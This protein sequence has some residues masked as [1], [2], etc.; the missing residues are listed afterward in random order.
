MIKRLLPWIAA[1]IGGILHFLGYVGFDQFY[2]EWIFLVPLLWAVR[3]QRPGRAFLIGWVAGIVG[4]A[5]GFYWIIQMFQQFAGVPWPLAALGL[6]F[7]S[8]A[9]GIVVATWAWATRLITRDTG[10]SVVWVAP[11]VWTAVEKFWPEIF[12]NYLGA[13]QYRLSSLTQIADL[14]GILGVS[15]LVVYINATI[16][17][18]ATCFVEKRRLAWR[19]LT[20]LAAAIVLVVCYGELRI[21]AMD[22]QVATAE[23]LTIGL[24]QVNRGAADTHIDPDTVLREHHE[25]SRT[26]VAGHPLDL[27]VWPEGVCRVN[28]SSR[29]SRLPTALLGDLGTP[30]LLGACLQLWDGDK[31][32]TSN[33]ALLTDASGRIIGSYDKTIL[34]PFGEYIP[35]GDIFPRLYSWSPFVSR[36][37]PGASEEPLLL[38]RHLLSVNICYED[39]FPGHIRKLMRGGRERRVPE[40]MF[41]LTND[42][43]YG[44]STEPMEHLA[45]ASFR[46][47]ENRRSLVRVTNTG[48]SAFVDPVGRIVSRTGVWTK[49]V[50]VDRIPLLKGRTAYAVMG[51]WIG[52]LCAAF[53]ISGIVQAFRISRRG[54]ELGRPRDE[55]D[56]KRQKGNRSEG[57]PPAR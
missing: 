37:W 27:I 41:N 40:V 18:V 29:D 51:D 26:L 56:G 20:V 19:P 1:V 39:I 45:L 28:L 52:W 47:I 17:A 2:L 3:E 38:G 42:S 30:M 44:N 6:L 43:W 11:V 5:G 21:R 8:A 22:R 36:F 23:K 50:L 34:V 13:S 7:L 9:N 53:S 55:K 31:V 10:W 15:F 48:V 24:V 32:R 12:P 35:F 46:S 49:E 16:Y 4:N 33:S 57:R 14:T 54:K 25:M